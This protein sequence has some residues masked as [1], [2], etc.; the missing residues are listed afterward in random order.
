M[1]A[2]TNGHGNIVKIL[3]DAGADLEAKDNV[4]NECSP[5]VFIGHAILLIGCNNA[6][7][8]VDSHH[9]GCL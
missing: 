6:V 8:W 5:F 7:A 2:A 3:A 4:S 9:E 1:K